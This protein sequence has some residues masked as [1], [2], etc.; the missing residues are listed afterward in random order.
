[1]KPY[2]PRA[3]RV[4]WN[5]D[6]SLSVY[7]SGGGARLLKTKMWI[8]D[9]SWLDAVAPFCE[10]WFGTSDREQWRIRKCKVS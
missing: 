2:K 10:G 3:L 9:K 7:P 8:T 1:M 5:K 6:L 4:V